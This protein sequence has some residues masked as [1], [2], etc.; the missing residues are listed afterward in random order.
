MLLKN[1]CQENPAKGEIQTA[2]L[3]RFGY[4]VDR[5]ECVKTVWEGKISLTVGLS[6]LASRYLLDRVC[7][8]WF[9]EGASAGSG[10]PLEGSV[11]LEGPA[12]A[13]LIIGR[14]VRV[15]SVESYKCVSS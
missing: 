2:V 1:L 14:L 4:K 15:W 5:S 10:H 8:L 6:T 3:P 11:C 9:E 7:R 13:E 12:A